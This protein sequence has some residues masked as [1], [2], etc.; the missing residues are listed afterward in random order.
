[1]AFTLAI[2]SMT[3]RAKS[4]SFLMTTR[5]TTRNASLNLMGGGFVPVV[6]PVLA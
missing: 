6:V 2:L 4:S 3:S 5:M 1:M